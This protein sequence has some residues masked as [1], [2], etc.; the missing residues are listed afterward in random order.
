MVKVDPGQMEQ[1]IVNLAVNARDAMLK[2]GKLTIETTNVEL[3]EGYTHT[4]LGVLPGA[5]VMLS[6][7]DTGTGMTKEVKEQIFDPFF[8]TKEKGKGTGLGLSTV[9]GIVKQSGGEIF[10]YS[11]VGHGTTFK[12]CFPRVFEPGEKLEKKE[13]GKEVPRGTETI[14]VVED[15]DMVLKIVVAILKNQGY[16]VLEATEGA[17]AL[18]ICEQEKKPIHLILTDVVMPQMS[19]TQF[20]EQLKQVR[21]DFKMLYMTGYAENAIFHHGLLEKGVHIIQKP[22]TVEKLARK[23][24]E[25]LDKK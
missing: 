3:D 2:G 6:V 19:G 5:Y 25:V 24:R 8:T 14:L 7:T 11:E 20:I 15:N 23:V 12:I 22:F 10:V 16:T 18:L 17:E 9:Y 21:E 4:H 1:V 13:I